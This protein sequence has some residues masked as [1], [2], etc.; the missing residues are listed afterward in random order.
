MHAAGHVPGGPAAT[1]LLMTVGGRVCQMGMSR[2]P[3]PVAGGSRARTWLLRQT[4]SKRCCSFHEQPPMPTE[5]L[6]NGHARP[7]CGGEGCGKLHERVSFSC[8][9]LA[10]LSITATA[11]SR[12]GCMTAARTAAAR[13]GRPR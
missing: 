7:R 3:S 12:V 9:A 13:K 10:A 6:G 2:V 4:T 11:R 1:N 5:H 8:E